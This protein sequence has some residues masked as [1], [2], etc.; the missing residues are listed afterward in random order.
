MEK[1]PQVLRG[2]MVVAVK[3]RIAV[4]A[5]EPFRAMPSNPPARKPDEP[6][7]VYVCH[8]HPETIAVQAGRCPIDGSNRMSQTLGELE[9]LQ[10][11]CPMHP[12]VTADKAGEVC[13]KCGGMALQAKVV[14]YAPKGQVLAVP[15]SAVVNT[16]L[17]KVV[18]VETMPGM[19]D[20]VEVVLG[21]RCGD[22]YPVLRGLEP[23]QKV[24]IA[25]AFLLDAE[26]RLNPSLAAGYFGAGKS[27]R[28]VTAAEKSITPGDDHPAPADPLQGLAASDHA[29]AEKQKVCPVTGLELGVMGA[30]KR[31]TVSGRVVFLCCEGCESK[32]RRE[33][34]KYLA[35][36]LRP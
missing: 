7:R 29:L 8:D 19:F 31:I 6:R 15:Q 35:K 1:P 11:W 36:V 3:F 4:S 23:G 27:N 5:L 17:R 16:G 10:W 9:R 32:M 28:A 34:E 25:G 26:T 14:F 30:P 13:K 33:P 24:A 2:G 20:G 21:P 22:Y 12:E 18:F